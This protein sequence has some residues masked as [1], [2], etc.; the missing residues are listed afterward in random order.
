MAAPDVAQ[1]LISHQITI[2]NTNRQFQLG[3]WNSRSMGLLSLDRKTTVVRM[4][5]LGRRSGVSGWSDNA[6]TGDGAP[7]EVGLSSF[8]LQSQGKG[9]RR[10]A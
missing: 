5:A 4:W 6:K 10:R 9:G 8:W 1:A 3:I 2:S 7:R